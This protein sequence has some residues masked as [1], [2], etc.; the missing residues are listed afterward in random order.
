[1]VAISAPIQHPAIRLVVPPHIVSLW[2]W[3]PCGGPDVAKERT[4][5]DKASI[6][7]D[8]NR[9]TSFDS[10]SEYSDGDY[11][12]TEHQ[13]HLAF[14]DGTNEDFDNHSANVTTINGN[15][16][17]SAVISQPKNDNNTDDIDSED[18]E[19]NLIT[20]IISQKSPTHI[21]IKLHVTDK[22]SSS[23]ESVLDHSNNIL[24]VALPEQIT[25]EASKQSFLSLLEF[26]E[27][28]LDCD[29]VVLCIR[30]DRPD[31][32]NLVKTFLFLGFQPLNP[33]SPLAPPQ[34][35][36]QNDDNLFLFYNIEE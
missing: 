19:D 4:D 9:K 32:A 30:K 33:K 29:G 13:Q 36:G 35:Y 17:V 1:M 14:V 25:H 16:G 18:D 34:E 22:I 28:K 10:A 8:Y 12:D 3:D 15:N 6:I 11:N 23:W 5:H 21:T 24:Y 31:R 27:E 7:F 2:V 26:A 20:Q